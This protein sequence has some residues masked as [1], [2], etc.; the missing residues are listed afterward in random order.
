MTD[1][2]IMKDQKKFFL[3]EKNSISLNIKEC[4][5]NKTMFRT[6]E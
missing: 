4:K 5:F 2:E 6:L 3:K 1:S